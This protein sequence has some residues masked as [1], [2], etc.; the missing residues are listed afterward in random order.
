MGEAKQSWVSTD[1][2]ASTNLPLHVLLTILGDQRMNVY[3]LDVAAD[4][5]MSCGLLFGLKGLLGL[6]QLY[7]LLEVLG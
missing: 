2:L 4:Q 7:E 6:W 3:C 1:R 5:R